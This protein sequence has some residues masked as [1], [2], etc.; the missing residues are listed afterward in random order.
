[1]LERVVAFIEQHQLLPADGT[2]VVAV[3][4]GA[5]SLCLLHLLHQLCGPTRCF[6]GVT[7]H[8]A[9]LDHMLRGATS[10]QE[11]RQVADL[12]SAWQIPFTLGSADVPALAKVEKRSLEEAAREARYRFLREVACGSPIAVAHHADDQVETILL[13]WL[14]G[15]GLAGLVGMPPRQQDIIRPLLTVTHAETLAYCQSQQIVPLED[16]SNSDPRFLRNRIRHELIPLLHELNPGIQSTL[17]RTAEVLRPDLDWL[18]AQVDACW[19]HVVID[20]RE[21][22]LSLRT[23]AFLGLALSLQRHLLRRVTARLCAGQSPL[24]PR[25]FALIEHLLTSHADHQERVLHLPQKIRLVQQNEVVI[26]ERLI[27]PHILSSVE[28]NAA[29][30]LSVP[31]SLALPGTPWMVQAELLPSDLTAYIK[32]EMQREHW[33]AVW[34]V[35]EPPTPHAVYIDGTF[36][37]ESIL[38]RTRRAGDRIR[39]LGMAHEKKVQDILSDAHIPRSRRETIPL[40]FS[41]AHC[42]W[43]AGSCLDDRVRLTSATQRILRLAV[44]PV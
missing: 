7:L 9:H 4:G 30:L 20:E 40:F 29:I 16:A 3:S 17:L 39:P 6:P 2:V 22:R 42:L 13:H 43:V 11:A 38:V 25:H 21:T 33:S 37:G 26:F 36:L 41:E 32:E 35:L 1:M 5:D 31:G 28:D 34:R 19:E 44:L 27:A 12:L 10:A 14:R 23:E 8:A 18:E 24:E 15:S